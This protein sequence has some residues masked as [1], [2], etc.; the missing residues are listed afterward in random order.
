[1]PHGVECD[2]GHPDALGWPGPVDGEMLA[3]AVGIS[4]RSVQCILEAHQLTLIVGKFRLR[5][6]GRIDGILLNQYLTDHSG[7]PYVSA[8]GKTEGV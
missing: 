4:L 5:V 1:M 2:F 8:H 3:K 6:L 7:T